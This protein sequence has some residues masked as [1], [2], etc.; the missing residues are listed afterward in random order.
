MLH[1]TALCRAYIIITF[2]VNNQ[3][4]HIARGI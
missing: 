2:P 4:R 3:H 1:S